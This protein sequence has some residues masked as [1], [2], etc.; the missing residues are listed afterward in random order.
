MSIILITAFAV[1]ALLLGSGVWVGLSLMGTAI[2]LFAIFR[3]MPIDRLLPQY[4]FNILTT[5]E[6]VALPLFVIMGEF[7]FRTRL[8]HSLFN[9]LAP[10]SGFLP[11]RLLHVNVIACSIFA[12]ISGSSAATTQVVGRMSLTELLKRGYSK[13]LA[14]GSL[15][16]AGTLGFLIPPSSVM[17]IYGVL[18]DESI[19]R[20][21]TAGFIPGFLLAGIFMS[22]IMIQCTI[23]P[24]IVPESE[25]N[26][27]QATWAVRIASLRELGPAMF[28]IIC[29]LG[30]MY[31]GIATPSEAAAVGVLGA[32]LVAWQQGGLSWRSV[33]DVSVA[34]VQTCSLMGLIIIGATIL[35]N[36]VA[37]LGLPNQISKFVV[38]MQLSP[39]M[40]IVALIVLYLILG[41][42]LEGFSMI[43]TTLPVVL[44]LV[45][46]AG[47]DKVWFGIFLVI[48]VEL[49]QITPPVGFN[50]FVINGL[51]GDGVG[52]IA[53]V[54]IP[55][56]IIMILYTLLLAL[57]PEIVLWLP[58]VLLG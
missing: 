27:R 20:L 47:F 56:L 57:F 43:V 22:W 11:G 31:G 44:P 18:G 15:A 51:T 25:R 2:T 40:L 6:L 35:G 19:L 33:R 58:R 24:D 3:D 23:R 50:L 8:S 32:V 13:D 21:F 28:L 37:F 34:S 48:V 7:L 38:D 53:R 17:I 14:L 41:C 5:S 54:T 4:I 49:A 12:A 46:A 9:G 1:L 16:G 45:T 36:A 39:M 52:Y 29:V 26:L 10:W 42:F 30:S 55:F